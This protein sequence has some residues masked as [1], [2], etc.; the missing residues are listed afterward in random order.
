[1]HGM[2]MPPPHSGCRSSGATGM[3]NAASVCREPPI[4]RLDP[5][6]SC[7]PSLVPLRSN[8]A[9]GN[10]H[11]CYVELEA[12]MPVRGIKWCSAA[13]A[14]RRAGCRNGAEPDH[15]GDAILGTTSVNWL[16]LALTYCVPYAV[17]TYGAVSLALKT[18]SPSVTTQPGGTS[19]G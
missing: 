6:A 4:A 12:R 2:L 1:M 16:K 8:D 15:Q 11:G 18:R 14:R 5:S 17:C 9:A 10:G 3:A 7:L 19:S 13:L